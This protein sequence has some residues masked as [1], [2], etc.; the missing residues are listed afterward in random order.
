MPIA[1]R[2]ID[3]MNAADKIV[4]LF[5]LPSPIVTNAESF[6]AFCRPLGISGRHCGSVSTL[7]EYLR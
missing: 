5:I 2:K 6:P 4:F 1:A 3:A 7:D